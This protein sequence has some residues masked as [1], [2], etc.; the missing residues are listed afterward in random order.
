MTNIILGIAIISMSV[1]IWTISM[2]LLKEKIRMN[3][4]YGFRIKKAFQS[5]ELW[6]KINKYGAGQF[7]YGSIF[8]FAAGFVLIIIPGL[9]DL[10]LPDMFFIILYL[11]IILMGI[12]VPVIRTIIYSNKL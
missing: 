7:I 12:I 1:L 8:L 3:K 4:F 9:I 10:Y 6:Y 5:D 2:P 11:V